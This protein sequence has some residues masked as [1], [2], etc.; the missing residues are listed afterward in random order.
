MAE[1][2]M[3]RTVKLGRKLITPNIPGVAQ[4]WA[5]KVGDRWYEIHGKSDS[6]TY[7]IVDRGYGYA[8][9]SG[10]G[11]LGGELVGKTNKSDAQIDAWIENW[12]KTNCH[13]SLM[14]TNCQKFAFEFI[15]WQTEGVYTI[16]H[17]VDAAMMASNGRKM[18]MMNGRTLGGFAASEDGNHIAR[19]GSGDSMASLGPLQYKNRSMEFKAQAVAGNPGLG[20]FVDASLQK[21]EVSAGNLVGVHVDLNINTGIGLRNGN[22]EAH[23]LGFGGK[24]GADGLE[25]N[26]PIGGANCSIM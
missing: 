22:F 4:H 24:I 14:A 21:A 9:D 13:Y 7:N 11:S 2:K 26:T 19:F 23:L 18:M 12:E 6:H 10:A 15:A 17:R 16:P 3:E 8:A 5:V 25:I 20:A 1:L